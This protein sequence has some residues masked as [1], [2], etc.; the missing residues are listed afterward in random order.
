MTLVST[1]TWSGAL[2]APRQQYQRTSFT[3]G[4]TDGWTMTAV[5][6]GVS[7]GA[8]A[9]DGDCVMERPGDAAWSGTAAVN[10]ARTAATDNAA[11]RT[12]R[13]FIAHLVWFGDGRSGT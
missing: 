3:P 9:S 2:P 7:D 6:M 4:A 13:D 1:A 5:G 12:K 11:A 8:A 10:A